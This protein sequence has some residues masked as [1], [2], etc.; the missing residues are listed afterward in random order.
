MLATAAWVFQATFLPAP[1][2]LV[3]P[4]IL[5]TGG[6]FLGF[7]EQTSMPIRSG[8]WIKRA[9]GLLLIGLAIWTVVPAP[10]EA[11]LPWQPYSDQALDQAREQ[12][13]TV[14][15]YFHA[16]WCGPCH[17][18]ERTTLSR[19]IVV[20]AA[21]NFVALRADMTDRDSPAVQA[22]ADKF[23]VVGLPAIIFFGADGEERR[24]LRV[25]GVESPDRFIK[26]LAAVQ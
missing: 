20:D 3:V 2:E 6:I 26:R 21:R 25:F 11:Q 13:R 14:L 7:F 17:V 22:I 4:S 16:D 1:I 8:P 15:L 12:K 10:P 9:V 24:L 18:L 23:G 19:R 5:L